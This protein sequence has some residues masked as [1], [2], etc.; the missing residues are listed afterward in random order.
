M[1]IIADLPSMIA[2]LVSSFRFIFPSFPSCSISLKLC[3]PAVPIE[4]Q[5]LLVT[6]KVIGVLFLSQSRADT[7]P[8]TSMLQSC[9]FLPVQWSQQASPVG[10]DQWDSLNPPASRIWEFGH[11]TL[12]IPCASRFSISS[13]LSI[14]PSLQEPYPNVA[15]HG[16]GL[17]LSPILILLITRLCWTKLVLCEWL[18]HWTLVSFRLG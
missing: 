17:A 8:F 5:T 6:Y 16:S 1:F 12:F 9:C 4:V 18:V 15:C 3:L 11:P 14:M 7:H 13:T 2:H 10:K